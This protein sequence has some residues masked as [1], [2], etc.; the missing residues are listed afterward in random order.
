MCE[1]VIVVGK[2]HATART[3]VDYIVVTDG[4]AKMHEFI[5]RVALLLLLFFLGV[6]MS[7]FFIGA[8]KKLSAARTT[9]DYFAYR[10][11]MVK[12]NESTEFRFSL[13]K[14]F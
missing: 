12:M 4:K 10:D 1:L 3:T 5:D 14:L 2:E 11:G 6:V 8:G 13:F 7:G 9:A